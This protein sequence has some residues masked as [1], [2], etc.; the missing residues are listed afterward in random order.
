MDTDT[1]AGSPASE[2]SADAADTAPLPVLN[3]LPGMLSDPGPFAPS[4]Q[5]FGQPPFVEQPASPDP[6]WSAPA[7]PTPQ[8]AGAST[9]QPIG[10]KPWGSGA[11]A[12]TVDFASWADKGPERSKRPLIIGGA[13]LAAVV[14]VGGVIAILPVGAATTLPRSPRPRHR[15]PR[16]PAETPMRRRG[17]CPCCRRAMRHRRVRPSNRPM[18]QSPKSN[19]VAATIRMGR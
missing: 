18:R 19:A 5:D 1:G 4:E 12:S 2:G 10:E 3:A 17:C 11:S 16:C 9:P 6:Y 7:A 15:R 13:V 14:L 8:F